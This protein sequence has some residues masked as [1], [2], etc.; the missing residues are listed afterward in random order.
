M[1]T[2]DILARC[3]RLMLRRS[4]EKGEVFMSKRKKD[5]QSGEV[6]SQT[7]N[8]DTKDAQN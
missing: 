5:K 7:E 4:T 1:Y 8:K 2:R 3:L 6:K